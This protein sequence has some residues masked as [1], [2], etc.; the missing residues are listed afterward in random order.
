[1]RVLLIILITEHGNPAM[2]SIYFNDQGM[3]NDAKTAI[4]ENVSHIKP[5]PLLDLLCLRE[6]EQPSQR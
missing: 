3:C 6:G 1:M 2:T 4:I 5:Q